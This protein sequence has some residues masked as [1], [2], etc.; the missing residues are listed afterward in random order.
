MEEEGGLCQTCFAGTLQLTAGI[1]VCETCGVTQQNFLEE[2]QEYQAATRRT[3]VRA[4][5]SEYKTEWKRVEE[6]EKLP[7]QEGIEAYIFAFQDLLQ[8]QIS[9]LERLDLISCCDV[10]RERVREIWF[11]YIQKSGVLESSFYEVIE[12]EIAASEEKML[13][14]DQGRK[15][16]RAS[17]IVT[18]HLNK[19]LPL[20]LSLTILFLGCW[21]MRETLDPMDICT[22]SSTGRI[23]YLGFW[24]I[25]KSS[26]E[27]YLTMFPKIFFCRPGVISPA[28]IYA[29]SRRLGSFLRYKVPPLHTMA[30]NQRYAVTLGLPEEILA[31]L[32]TCQF[33]YGGDINSSELYL[34]D[35]FKTPWAMQATKTAFY[36]DVILSCVEDRS[37]WDSLIQSSFEN[38]LHSDRLMPHRVRSR[39]VIQLNVR[40]LDRYIKYLEDV[41]F[42]FDESMED[43]EFIMCKL[44]KFSCSDRLDETPMPADEDSK[45]TGMDFTLKHPPVICQSSPQSSSY[46]LLQISLCYLSWSSPHLMKQMGKEHPKPISTWKTGNDTSMITE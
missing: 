18:M 45:K 7:I 36:V 16:S 46:S 38:L 32:S 11:L 22:L 21:M 17:A 39:D 26:L 35:L 41:Y 43:F 1:L 33:L 30:W 14:D 9:Q 13:E 25:F 42:Q 2:T 37:A 28:K 10:F 8:I 34:C 3:E 29:Q 5:P 6:K 15:T 19:F 24:K 20:S 40:D 27:Q 4:A 44:K 23:E 12:R 31:P